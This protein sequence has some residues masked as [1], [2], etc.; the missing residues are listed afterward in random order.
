MAIRRLSTTSITSTGGKSSKL[1]D[2]ETTLGTFESIATATVDASGAS[3]IDFTNIPQTYKHLQIRGIAKFSTASSLAFT[4][5][6]DTGNNYAIHHICGNGASASS[7]NA[8][9]LGTIRIQRQEGVSATANIFTGFVLDILDYNNTNKYKT[10][11]S[12]A[13]DDK[14]GSGS[15]SLESGLWMNTSAISSITF[16]SPSAY[17]FSQYSSFALYGIRGA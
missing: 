2:Q 5:N 3:S 1:W 15:I 16:T 9:S 4:F 12:L 17:T 14:N 8:T 6:S 13:G 10:T 11:R 7:N